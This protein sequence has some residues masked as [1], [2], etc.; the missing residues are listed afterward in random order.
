MYL[1]CRS[2]TAQRA[3]VVGLLQWVCLRNTLP[4]SSIPSKT[5]WSACQSS[6][7]TLHSQTPAWRPS[8][9]SAT[10]PNTWQKN[11]TWVTSLW[12]SEMT[13][14]KHQRI[15][16]IS[17]GERAWFVITQTGS[18]RIFQGGFGM[19]RGAL[20][21]VIASWVQVCAETFFFPCCNCSWFSWSS[22]RLSSGTHAGHMEGAVIGFVW[23]WQAVGA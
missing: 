15:I 23:W 21:F 3:C 10:V 19:R 16:D 18:P 22:L 8:V 5:L 2:C 13:V 6:P 17:S 20:K 12:L 1:S 14:W 11:L 4:P 7:A 9:S